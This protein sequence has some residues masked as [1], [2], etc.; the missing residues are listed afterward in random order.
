MVARRPFF[1]AASS[2]AVVVG[3]VYLVLETTLVLK[4]IRAVVDGHGVS[5]GWAVFE[6]LWG[7]A[8]V[9]AAVALLAAAAVSSEGDSLA[10]PLA[11]DS[12]CGLSVV[13]E[14]P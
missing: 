5:T 3:G 13:A 6:L 2:V 14:P 11:W 12:S 4:S 7:T 8:H 1:A 9:A 10:V